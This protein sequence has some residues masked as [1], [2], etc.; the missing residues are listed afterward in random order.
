MFGS[1]QS[2]ALAT[3]HASLYL[4]HADKNVGVNGNDAFAHAFAHAFADKL[5]CEFTGICLLVRNIDIIL[6]ITMDNTGD[7]KGITYIGFI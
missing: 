6:A 5:I 1:L 7:N 4:F 3:A 2:L